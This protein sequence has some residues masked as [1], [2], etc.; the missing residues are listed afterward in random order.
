MILPISPEK[1]I[2]YLLATVALKI[3]QS[4]NL[5]EILQVTVQEILQLIESDRV[6]IYQFKPQGENILTVEA[7]SHPKWSILKNNINLQHCQ[8]TSSFLSSCQ[9]AKVIANIDESN[10]KFCQK[11]SVRA[12]LIVPIILPVTPVSAS[13]L[14]GLLVINQC[15]RS[16]KWHKAEINIIQEL[17]NHLAIAIQQ[18]ELLAKQ[19]QKLQAEEELRRSQE[20]L[21][22]ALESSGDGL[23]DWNIITDEVY[24]SPQWLQMLGYEPDELPASY[25]TWEKL[26]HPEDK[27]WVMKVLHDHLQDSSVPYAFD[28]RLRTKSGEWKWIANYGKVV[29]RDRHGRPIRMVGTHKDISAR[30]QVEAELLHKSA[31]LAEFSYN[32]KHLHR[33][34][35]TNYSSLKKLFSDYLKTGCSIFQC[36][37]GIISRVQAQTYTIYAVKSD[38]Q[39]ISKN[40][41]FDLEKTLCAEVVRTKK[42]IAYNNIGADLQLHRHPVYQNL[43]LECYIG[44]PILV[45]G[46]VYGT[47][48]FSSNQVRNRDFSIH[49]REIIELMAQSIGKFIEAYQIEIQRQ[50]TEIKLRKAKEELELRVNRRTAQL[51][52]ANRLLQQEL[53]ERE[54]AQAALQES[55]TRFQTMAN[56]FPLLMWIANEEGKCTFFNKSWLDYTGKKMEEEL[57][58]GWTKE[59][60]P[61]DLTKCIAI[62]QES[63]KSRQPFQQEYRLKRWDGKY[64]WLL[65]YGTPR[66]RPDGSFAGYI[67]SCLDISGRKKIEASL[68]ESER[69]WRT[70][71]KNVRMLVVALDRQGKVDYVNP[72]LLEVTEYNQEEVLGQKWINKFIRP[73]DRLE[74]AKF[75]NKLLQPNSSSQNHLKIILTKSGESKVVAW[76]ITQ[77][78]NL[79]GKPIGMMCIGQDITERH[80]IEKMKDEFISVVSHELRT[81][82]TAVHG[83]LCLLVKGAV[84]PE[85]TQ[86]KRTLQIAAESA[87]R[88]VRLVKDILELERLES[89]KIELIKQK[90]NA[91]ELILHAIEQIQLM[92]DRAG[93]HLKLQKADVVFYADGDRLIQVLT[94]LLTNAIKFSEQGSSVCL[95]AQIKYPDKLQQK[96]H[97][98]FVVQDQ[99]R[100]IP[101]EQLESIFERFHQVDT[102][103]SRKKG[104]T[105]LGL[106]ICRNIVEQ[107]GGKIWVESILGEGSTFY[108]TI[109]LSE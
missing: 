19:Q 40:Q 33:L 46:E 50:Q 93:V 62:H 101:V 15:S 43:Q 30:K 12:N 58:Y 57:G 61:Q 109:P 89:A 70:L 52:K 64:R 78:R 86:G 77:L 9:Q 107:H 39:S 26:I 42:T 47:L 102:S 100:G 44:T 48:N 2:N 13:Y 8:F 37:T 66:Y 24:L 17:T 106:A 76:N 88:L 81:P 85:S 51:R 20:R 94:N 18:A 87:E 75:F 35:T 34:N 104:G 99:G 65:D 38:L 98:L 25:Y 84:T 83:A 21:Q 60:H 54:S 103:D 63:F 73:Q 59:V 3:R 4:F 53:Q 14:W 29:T 32:L 28:H 16:R 56:C 92:A 45:N 105:G 31:E 71:L 41:Q 22:L 55:E 7:F 108:F 67:G 95:C 96:P 1:E 80:A 10:C 69:R 79:Q 82:L 6:F 72:Y 74:A 97:I 68:Q 36:A 91:K 5:Q 11:F 90:V 23:W 49:E 27:P